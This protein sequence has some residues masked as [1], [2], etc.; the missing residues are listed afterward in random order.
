M[1]QQEF[2]DKFGVPVYQYYGQKES[3]SLVEMPD[4]AS[5]VLDSVGKPVSGTEV[6]IDHPDEHG[7]GEIQYRSE[8][9][10]P[11]YIEDG[12]FKPRIAMPGGW[13]GTG[14]IGF[15][16]SQGYLFVR[17]RSSSFINVGGLKVAPAEIEA[18]LCQFP[19]VCGVK[20]DKVANYLLG[21]VPVAYVAIPGAGAETLNKIRQFCRERMAKHKVP[22]R[23][24]LLEELAINA[25]GKLQ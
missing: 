8:R 23:I 4:D 12:H 1:L 21:E 25:V 5:P 16:N 19:G 6:R 24:I 13:F 2:Q 18:V 3:I 7:Q 11:G 15:T 10:A 20:I 22:R 17:G 14:D 9:A